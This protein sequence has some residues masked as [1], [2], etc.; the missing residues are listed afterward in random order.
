MKR[1]LLLSLILC[2]WNLGAASQGLFESS[3]AGDAEDTGSKNLSIGGFVRSALYLGNTP[4]E[5]KPYLQSAYGQAGLLLKAN[6][7]TMAIAKADI[8]F[9]FG[10]E[11]QERISELEIREA[12]VDLQTGPA[13]FRFGKLISPWGKEAY[14]IR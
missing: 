3:L 8:R 7:G 14:S 12:Y 9:R 4:L 6:A 5:E 2:V 10:S 13:G 1:A 11:W